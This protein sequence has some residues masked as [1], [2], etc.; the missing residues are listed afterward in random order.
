LLVLDG[1]KVPNVPTDVMDSNIA[2]DHAPTRRGDW[3]DGSYYNSYFLNNRNTFR[4]PFY[5]V[6]AINVDKKFELDN[7]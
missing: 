4:I 2:Y 6:E 3:V 5:V 7:S 1:N